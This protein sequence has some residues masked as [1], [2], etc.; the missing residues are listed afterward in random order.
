MVMGSQA[1]Q[2]LQ[3]QSHNEHSCQFTSQASLA[4]FSTL[5]GCS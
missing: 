1:M 2:S 3:A 4:I 5:R